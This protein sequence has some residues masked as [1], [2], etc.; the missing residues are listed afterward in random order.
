LGNI[1]FLEIPNVYESNKDPEKFC[2]K[3]MYNTIEPQM[4][5]SY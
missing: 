3:E 1:A 5:S 4:D 2:R